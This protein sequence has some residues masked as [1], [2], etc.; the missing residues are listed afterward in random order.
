MYGWLDAVYEGTTCYNLPEA[1]MTNWVS[2]IKSRNVWW[3]N[4]ELE[5][6]MEYGYDSYNGNISREMIYESKW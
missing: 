5:I 3:N 2:S 4:S 6:C 1:S